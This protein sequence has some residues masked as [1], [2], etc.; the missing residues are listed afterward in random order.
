MTLHSRDRVIL[1]LQ[2]AIKSRNLRRLTSRIYTLMNGYSLK[3]FGF[4][5]PR[6][7]GKYESWQDT[8]SMMRIL[9]RAGFEVKVMNVGIHTVLGG[10]LK[11]K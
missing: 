6:I 11:R 5:F 3:Y 2:E 9:T 1:G 10:V 7:D 8:P 4:L